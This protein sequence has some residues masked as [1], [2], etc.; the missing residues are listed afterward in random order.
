MSLWYFYTLD[1]VYRKINA[2]NINYW[3]I[4]IG[5]TLCT[6]DDATD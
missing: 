3:L 4:E 1:V 6:T 2:L 5:E